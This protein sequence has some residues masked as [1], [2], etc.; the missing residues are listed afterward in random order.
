MRLKRS[1]QRATTG[2]LGALVLVVGFTLPVEARTRR[3]P[4]KARFA[5]AV[6]A[7]KSSKPITGPLP[8]K[9]VL[10]LALRAYA[11]GEA[12]G[13]FR[14]PLRPEGQVI[15]IEHRAEQVKEGHGGDHLGAEHGYLSLSSDSF[16]SFPRSA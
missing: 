11:C 1:W 5:R 2:V 7:K 15:E 9:P 8:R 13:Y 4:H 12:L 3:A 16:V 14:Q 10:D 6:P